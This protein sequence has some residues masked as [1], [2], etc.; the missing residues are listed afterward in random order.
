M[1]N[2]FRIFLLILLLNSICAGNSFAQGYSL[3]TEFL[4]NV[5]QLYFQQHRYTEARDALKKCLIICPHHK[6]AKQLLRHCENKIASASLPLAQIL[7]ESRQSNS[8][9]TGKITKVDKEKA[10]LSLSENN[11][12]QK[13]MLLALENAKEEFCREGASSS[14]MQ[15]HQVSQ[16]AFNSPNNQQYR[17]Y[18]AEKMPPSSSDKQKGNAVSPNGLLREESKAHRSLSD[19]QKGNVTHYNNPII[20]VQRGAWT[21]KKGELYAEIYTK[22]YW[23]NHQFDNHGHK[24]RWDY[25][26]EYYEVTTEYKIEYG[27]TDRYTAML[28]LPFKEAHWKDDFRKYARSG[29]VYLWP[30][31]KY[32]LFKEPFIC[33]LQSRVKLPLHINENAVPALGKQQI[34]AEI[35]LLTA[36]SWYKLPGYSKFE[37]GFRARNE[38]PANEI[39]YFFELGYNLWSGLILKSTIDAQEGLAQTGGIDEDWVKFT[40][41][42]IFKIRDLLNIEFGYGNTFAGKNTSAAQELYL[43]VSSQW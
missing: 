37:L 15:N 32:L 36:Q 25:N 28:Y 9:R 34:D 1:V 3:T 4:F 14:E 10:A 39:I 11:L 19:K 27:L 5:G 40:I 20:P 6:E 17:N 23:H 12:Q 7:R 21:L 13:A 24:K 26:G 41:G 2:K 38:E 18:S 22:Y 42:P 43:T 16:S 29:F 31:V 30:G 33:S 8:Q 35:K